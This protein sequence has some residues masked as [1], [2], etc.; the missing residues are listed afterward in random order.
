MIAVFD[1]VFMGPPH[2]A[3]P[4]LQRGMTVFLGR[5]D[6]LDDFET[7]ELR[8]AEIEGLLPPA[9]ACAARKASDRVQASKSA[10]LRQTVCEE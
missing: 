4:R 10:W 3:A 2:S 8:V 9:L 7:L 5:Q 6:L 1:Q